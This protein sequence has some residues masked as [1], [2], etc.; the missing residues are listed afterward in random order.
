MIQNLPPAQF[1]AS[2]VLATT[3]SRKT[4]LPTEI[5]ELS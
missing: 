1:R 5:E 4:R 3:R 2:R